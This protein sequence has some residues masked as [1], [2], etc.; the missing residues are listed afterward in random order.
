VVASPYANKLAREAGVDIADATPTGLGGRIVA[1]DV[2][3]LVKSGAPRMCSTAGP[4]QGANRKGHF[5]RPVASVAAGCHWLQIIPCTCTCT[6]TPSTR[7]PATDQAAPVCEASPDCSPSRIHSS[8]RRPAVLLADS[9]APAAGGKGAKKQDTKGPKSPAP[10]AQG[11]GAE[12]CR[13]T[14]PWS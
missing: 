1:A 11:G 6:T 12:V 10:S 2:E 5:A 9:A 4:E 3:Q 7:G 14:P 8:S 13:P